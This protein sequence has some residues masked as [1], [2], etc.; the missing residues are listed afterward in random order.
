MSIPRYYTRIST[1]GTK[2]QHQILVKEN[3]F[4]YTYT[5]NVQISLKITSTRSST[6][7]VRLMKDADT[8]A[9]EKC[10]SRGESMA[11]DQFI[12]L[13]MVSSNYVA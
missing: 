2:K 3:M 11:I 9:Q 10:S 8:Q 12:Q 6:S 5:Y 1:R 13:L 4:S 7:Q